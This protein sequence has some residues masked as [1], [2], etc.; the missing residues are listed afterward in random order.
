MSETIWAIVPTEEQSYGE[1]VGLYTDYD[2]AK[3][4]VDAIHATQRSVN[5]DHERYDIIM[6]PAVDK[7]VKQMWRVLYNAEGVRGNRVAF[8]TAFEGES[9]MVHP[10]GA[11]HIV[12]KTVERADRMYDE[13]VGKR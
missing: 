1:P 3:A 11:V 9:T 2:E 8:L 6:V 10:N 7:P 4:V 12:A 5:T 13:Y